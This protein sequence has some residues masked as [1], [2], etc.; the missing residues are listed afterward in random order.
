MPIDAR[1]KAAYLMRAGKVD[2]ALSIYQVLAAQNPRNIER[3]KELMW[4]LWQA[5]HYAETTAAATKLSLLLPKETEPLNLLARARTMLGERQAALFIYEKSLALNPDQL[6]VRLAIVRLHIDLKDLDTATAELTLLKA[7]YPQDSTIYADQARIA[8]L[9]GVYEEALTLWAQAIALEPDNFL[10]KVHEIETLYRLGQMPLARERLKTLVEEDQ[11]PWPGKDRRGIW[12]LVET[13]QGTAEDQAGPLRPYLHPLGLD[14][15]QI[16]LALARLYSDLRDYDSA[17]EIL[18]ELE[19]THKDNPEIYSRLA[20][21]Y[22]LRGLYSEAAQ[23]WESAS[24]LSPDDV[25]FQF[26][27]ARSLYYAGDRKTARA[28]LQDVT[29]RQSNYKWR[30]IDFLTDVALI[31]NDLGNAQEYL[32]SNLSDLHRPDEPRY[33]RLASI[34]AELGEINKSVETLD[35]F[36]AQNPRDGRAMMFKADVLVQHGRVA[37]AVDIYQEVLRLNPAVVRAYFSLADAYNALHKPHEALSNIEKACALDPTDPFLLIWHARYLY[38][39]GDVRGSTALLKSFLATAPR[40]AVPSLLYHGLSSLAHDPLLAY[41]VHLSSATFDDHMRAFVAA[42]YQPVTAEDMNDWVL[43]RKDLPVKKPLMIAFD[44]ARLD[45]FQNADPILEKHNLKATMFVPLVNVDKNL[46]GYASWEQ[47]R[48][49]QKTGRWDLELHGD[50]GHIRIPVD[51]EGRAGLYLINQQWLP[52][53]HRYETI[54]EWAQRVANDH[55]SGKRKMLEHLGKT[56]V[57]FAYPE[58]DFGQLGLTSSPGAAEINHAEA[59]KAY[60][61]SYH[62]DSFG[63]NIRSRDPQLLTRME[64]RKGMT[65]LDLVEGFAEKNPFTLA[66]ITLLRQAT[67]QGNIHNSLRLLDDLKKDSDLSPQVL[68]TQEAQIHYAARDLTQAERLAEQ[69]STFGDTSDLQSLKS[70]IDTQKRFIW[71]PTFIYQEDNRQ[72]KDWIFHQ[73][74]ATWSMGNARW[75]LHHLR[76]SY[77]GPATTDVTQN[78]VGA[79]TAIRLGL[80]HTLDARLLG[81]FLSGQSDKTTYTTAAGLRSQWTDQ[82]AT[83]VEAGRS[84]ADTAAALNDGIAQ[85]YVHA[86]VSWIQDGPWLMKSQAKLGDFTDSNRL[87]DGQFELTRQLFIE[88][89]FR[90]G[91][92]FEIENMKD[93]SPDYYSPQHLIVHHAVFQF[94]TRLPPG[95]Y[96]D[97]RYLPGYGKE[98]GANSQFVNDLELSMPVP[99]GKQTML[100]PEIWLSRTPIYHRD[101]YSVSLTH[102]F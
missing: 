91:Y 95:F 92:H 58:G 4:A 32:E 40:P 5:G 74:L 81:Q 26:E 43:G 25:N 14:E 94:S 37:E 39:V 72:D 69:A 100:T 71:N 21:Q 31:N 1:E 16:G 11:H 15:V 22:F 13:E 101:S 27:Q 12:A 46:P 90:V 70:S 86:S 52:M 18:L 49:Y 56:P 33:M 45:A 65:G 73:T 79:A 10:F 44:D 41:S 51:A 80:F 63:I 50:L 35:T 9:K 88:T 17:S 83:A 78:A 84:L 57:A 67:W 99:L 82:W 68:L 34:Y 61:T 87:Y 20:R 2:E 85:R 38:D 64:P 28:K 89:D 29:Q 48:D 7:R 54:Q 76:G 8:F 60:G 98:D 55:A 24:K 42:G 102:R 19:K 66:R 77:E 75:I 47:L 3:L 96:F 30:A 59:A 23:A 53:E 97:L 36:I 62:Q 6:S 93:I